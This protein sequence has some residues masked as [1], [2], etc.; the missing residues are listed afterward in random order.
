MKILSSESLSVRWE[1]TVK[2]IP[3]YGLLKAK[4]LECKYYNDASILCTEFVQSTGVCALW[5]I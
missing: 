3:I 2:G 1:S 4:V 5:D